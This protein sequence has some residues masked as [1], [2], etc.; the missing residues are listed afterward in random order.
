M[1]ASAV[2]ESF[3]RITVDGDTSTNDT[4][5]CLANGLAAN[6]LPRGRSLSQ[7]ESLIGNALKELAWMIVLDG[8]GAT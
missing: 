4:A 1:S 6:P 5:V 2:E 8:E 3:N 7:V